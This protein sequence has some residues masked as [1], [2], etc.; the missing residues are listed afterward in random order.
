MA[1]IL[2]TSAVFVKEVSSIS[3]NIAGKYLLPSMR[4]A[5]EI[6]LKGILGDALLAKCKTLVK[7]GRIGN[8]NNAAY[9]EL[10]DRCQYYLA[11]QSIV[12]MT[13]K[14]NYK[15]TNFG[16]AKT[17]DENIQAASQDEVF[18][19]QYYYQSKADACCLDI[20]NFILEHRA[21][22]PEVNDR[23]CNK[24]KSNL[25]SSASC[26]VFLGGARGKRRV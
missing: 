13:N 4:E 25:M 22:Y 16:V 24:I 8:A 14:V 6:G 3:D 17:T 19:L 10:V 21:D 20:Q 5:Q 7:E 1:E 23:H 18:K 12:E 11:Y 26:G 2:L 15:L 9:K